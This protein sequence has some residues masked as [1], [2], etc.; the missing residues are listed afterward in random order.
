MSATVIAPAD[1]RDRAV[2]LFTY[3]KE[4]SV[5]RTKA[6]RTWE[7]YDKVLW[8]ADV[9]EEPGFH[10][11]AW[12]RDAETDNETWIEAHKPRPRP[13]PPDPPEP[14]I[15]WLVDVL[16]VSDSS[17]EV[18]ELHTSIPIEPLPS[19]EG[20]VENQTIPAESAGEETADEVGNQEEHYTELTDHPEIAERWERYLQYQ[21]QPWAEEDR[22]LHAAQTVYTDLFSIYQRQ[23]RLGEQYEVVL[24]L[25]L[26]SWRTP[27][28]Q[29]VQRHLVTG[30]ASLAFDPVRGIITVGPAAD[31]ASLT[32]E[33]DMLEAQERP[34]LTEQR[35]IESQL[36]DLGDDAWDQIKLASLFQAWVH[37]VSSRGTFDDTLDPIAMLGDDPIIH[38]AP[39]L[40]LRKRTER[41]LIRFFD[42][43]VD[44]LKQGSPIPS[45]IQRLVEVVDDLDGG[46]TEDLSAISVDGGSSPSPPDGDVYFPL[47]ANDEQLDII[48]RLRTRQ[49]ILVQGPPGTGKSHTIANLVCHLLATGQRVL[50]TSH[51]PRALRVLHDKIPA[52]VSSLC[53]SLLGNDRTALEELETAVHGITNRHAQWDPRQH[54]RTIEQLGKKLDDAR[55][56]EAT[57]HGNLRSLQ[58]HESY[59][60]SLSF[61]GYEGTAATIARRIGEEAARLAWIA[62]RPQEATACPLN[63]EEATE[64]LE[65]LRSLTPEREAS[66]LQAVPGLAELLSPDQFS[67][68]HRVEVSARATVD[69]TASGQAHAAYAALGEATHD[70]RLA[71]SAS[72]HDVQHRA[73]AI[74]RQAKPW[75]RAA[76]SDVLA[77]QDRIWRQLRDVTRE[78]LAPIE[79]KAHAADARRL[80]GIDG[81]DRAVVKRH[82]TALFQHLE[83]GGGKGVGPFRPPAVKDGSYLLDAV[84]VDGHACDNPTTLRALLDWIEVNDRLDTLRRYWEPYDK[85]APGPLSAQAVSYHDL[86]EV[87]EEAIQLG[88]GVNRL[89]QALSAMS[90]NGGPSLAEAA[91]RTA[92]RESVEAAKAAVA[93]REATAPLREMELLISRVGIALNP[94]PV[95]ETLLA[96]IR[97]RDPRRFAEGYEVV[98]GV[99]ADREALDRR[100]LLLNR[101]R[102]EAPALIADLT[103]SHADP[104]W[105]ERLHHWE[106]AWDRARAVAWLERRE[107]PGFERR[108]HRDLD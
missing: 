97:A 21:W 11:A 70:Q 69:A 5:L 85:P 6:I 23:Q 56:H 43:I 86:N 72:L 14:V 31:G 90:G 101:L 20:D 54:Q 64:L 98:Q 66:S 92:L 7:Q 32:L 102:S 28:G 77:G 78:N 37:A 103:A 39:A 45:G 52:E 12:F 26:L 24:G 79:E 44:Q 71:L 42:E 73:D 46:S 16:Q 100:D 8:F 40:I 75:I 18:P 15:P 74:N 65:L 41:S 93:L 96:A 1:H 67:E 81:R 36:A 107:D 30:Q 27:A 22:R 2:S 63:R 95:V 49:G 35:T 33:H 4:L 13:A 76:S 47:P 25:G 29:R 108:L 51:T 60:H 10:C 9:P 19:S 84:T 94:H 50:V 3:L 38:L 87:V 58:E 61:G 80:T 62:D 53:V 48:E 57:L 68:H 17:L 88:E 59:R 34:D 55:R 99:D 82:A 104:N 91:E 105:D 89:Q 106:A 83:G